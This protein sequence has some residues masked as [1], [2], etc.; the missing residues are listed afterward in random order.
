MD[1]EAEVGRMDVLTRNTDFLESFV[2]VADRHFAR[3]KD[4]GDKGTCLNA[5][6]VD[7]EDY[8]QVSAFDRY[9]SRNDWEKFPSRVEANVDRILQLFDNAEIKST[10]FILG[11][12]AERHPNMVRRIAAQGH[13]IASHGWMHH[14]VRE[15]KQSEFAE[16]ISRTKYTLEDI[17]GERVAGYRAA[18]YSVDETTPWAHDELFNAGYLY[19][20]SVV[21]IVHDHYGIP[22]AP[23]FPFHVNPSGILEIPIS[24]YKMKNSNRPCGGGGWFRLYPYQLTRYALRHINQQENKPC[25]FY[26][27]PWEIDHQQPRQ[28]GIDLK[29]RVRHYINLKSVESK[30]Q[31]LLCDFDWG[32]MDDIYL[33]KS[34][35]F[36]ESELFT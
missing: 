9:I 24:T 6:S 33:P 13:E 34:S 3:S 36:G 4:S 12:V 26:F 30:L 29:T 10:F 19:S 27:H 14:R 16:D 17:S 31:A 15:Q 25:V 35:E 7:V 23:R 18:S 1:R 20:S 2:P 28:K 11:W 22:G 5:M 32:R 8:Y 21:P